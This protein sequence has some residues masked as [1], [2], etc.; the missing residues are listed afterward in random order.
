MAGNE[1]SRSLYERTVALAPGEQHPNERTL[2]FHKSAVRRPDLSAN[3][4]G[5]RA[6]RRGAHDEAYELIWFDPSVM[7]RAR[8]DARWKELL[9]SLDESEPD[10][11]LDNPA[12]AEDAK[13]FEDQ[14][15]MFHLL[16][17]APALEPTEANDAL[18]RAVRS[19]GKLLA[20]L[21]IVEG[22]LTFSLEPLDALRL[23]VAVATPFQVGDEH[24]SNA[25]AA[26]R[27]LLEI[28]DL[29]AGIPICE[30][31]LKGI[32]EAF[33]SAKRP[34]PPR[35]LAEQVELALLDERRYQ[36][37]DVLGANQLRTLVGAPDQ[38]PLVAYLPEHIESHL[39]L[40]VTFR[41][42]MMAL[43]HPRV[44]AR[45]AARCA[46]QVVGLVRTIALA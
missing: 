3:E 1:D 35:F 41:A 31:Y 21:V 25:I 19:D 12:L 27:H 20:P 42:R 6:T 14:R 10:P 30:A 11:E 37:R 32:R 5:P 2:P 45:E 22:A 9:V 34:V 26:A 43:V 38:P 24:L 13:T 29:P 44:D 16:A 40:D 23:A 18:R 46:L 4:P 39:P 15:E 28:P 8:R 7:P 36:K 17:N 33:T